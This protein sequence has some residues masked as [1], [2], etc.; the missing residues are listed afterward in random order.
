LRP[1]TGFSTGRRRSLG[2]SHGPVGLPASTSL[3]RA[4]RWRSHF[5]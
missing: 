2:A 1:S 4:I 3:P 5:G